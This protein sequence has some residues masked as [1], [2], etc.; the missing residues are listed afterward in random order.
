M[1]LDVISDISAYLRLPHSPAHEMHSRE[2]I[3][4][5]PLKAFS[6]E[7]LSLKICS[8]PF[9]WFDV[10]HFKSQKLDARLVIVYANFP[11]SLS[12]SPWLSLGWWFLILEP[13]NMYTNDCWVLDLVGMA[14]KCKQKKAF[15]IITMHVEQQHPSVLIKLIS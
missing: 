11:L 14:F 5:C 9:N 13:Q 6:S 15:N 1:I 8:K 4:L 12:L 10:L 2:N 3:F 7:N